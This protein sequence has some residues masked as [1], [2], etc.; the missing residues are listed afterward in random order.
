MEGD[1]TITKRHCL[2]LIVESEILNRL[3]LGNVNDWEWYEKSMN[4]KSI[5]SVD[6][7]TESERVCISKL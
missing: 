3:L 6:E 7:F 4:P 1:I 2:K 5:P